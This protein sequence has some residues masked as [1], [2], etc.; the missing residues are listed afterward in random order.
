MVEKS[1]TYAVTL[2]LPDKIAQN[3]RHIAAKTHRPLTDVLLGWL[4]QIATDLPVEDLTNEQVLAVSSMQ[5]DPAIQAELSELLASNRE[6]TLSHQQR[7][8]LEELMHLYRRNLVRKAQALKVSVD[9]G[10]R[11]PLYTHAD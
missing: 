3:A 2:D 7:L 5:L 6:G 1:M 10:L 9:R 11:P 8:R 4:D